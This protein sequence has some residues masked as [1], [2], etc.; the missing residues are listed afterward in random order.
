[1]SDV[2]RRALQSL[3]RDA[4]RASRKEDPALMI[5]IGLRDAETEIGEED[6]YGEAG[7][8]DDDEVMPGRARRRRDDTDR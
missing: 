1:M 6:E 5:A 2:A 3:R 4:L 7:A 8:E